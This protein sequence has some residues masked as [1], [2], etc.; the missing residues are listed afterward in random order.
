MPQRALN[1]SRFKHF[2]GEVPHTPN[3][4]GDT[5]PIPS[6]DIGWRILVKL[7]IVNILPSIHNSYYNPVR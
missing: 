2:Q 3:W 1:A 7:S 6:S 4:E 5:P